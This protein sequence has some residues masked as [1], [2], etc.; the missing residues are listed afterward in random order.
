MAEKRG[1]PSRPRSPWRRLMRHEATPGILLLACAALAIAL[2]NSPLHHAFH[3]ALH[4]PLPA[5][6]LAKLDT[7]HAWINDGL[8]A[9]F[10]FVVGLE[11]KRETVSGA[12]SDARRRR[13]PVLAA[14]AGMAVPAIVFLA[15][16]QGQSMLHRGWAIPAATDIA[17]AMGVLALIGR[18]VPSSIRLFLLTVAVVDDLGAVLV[19]AFFYTSGVA[20][21]WLAGAAAVFGVLL[22]LNRA[23]ASRVAPYAALGVLLWVCVLQSGVHATVAGVLAALTVPMKLDRHGDSPLLRLEHG[24]VPFNGFVVVPLFGLA[25]AGVAL[26]QAGLAGVLA[27]L[28]LAIAAGLFLGKQAGVLGAVLGAERLGLAP[29][30]AGAGVLHIWGMA[31]LCGIGFTMSLFIAALAFPADPDLVEQ[32]KLGILGGSLLSALAGALVLRMAPARLP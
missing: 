22:A 25:N 31:L 15:V 12:L 29:R 13:L 16:S 18:R 7:V 30:P 11:I 23:G 3:A 10:F 24:L 1:S 17:F 19:I 4:T 21:A 6:P 8:M 20:W 28:P 26:G 14:M 27:P 32:A 5:A 9:V 2:A